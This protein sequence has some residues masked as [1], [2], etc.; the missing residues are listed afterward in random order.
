[1]YQKILSFVLILFFTLIKLAH[2]DETPQILNLVYKAQEMLA[3]EKP[4]LISRNKKVYGR[5]VPLAIYDTE[6]KTILIIRADVSLERDVVINRKIEK[7]VDVSNVRPPD[8]LVY[9]IGGNGINAEFQ[10]AKDG[11]VYPFLGWN[12]IREKGHETMVYSPYTDYLA[13]KE[14]VD[15]GNKYLKTA[16]LNA[17]DELKK[18]FVLSR[19]VRGSLVADVISERIIF[20]LAL[21]EHMDHGE[22]EDKGDVY[23]MNKV[24]TQLALN[25]EKTF[26]YAKSSAGALC[27]MQIMRTTYGGV[28]GKKGK[29]APGVLQLY[30]NAKLPIDPVIGSCGSHSQATKVAYLV[31][32]DKLA[33]MPSDFKGKFVNEPKRYGY[34]LA[35][36]YNGGSGRAINIYKGIREPRIYELVSDIFS[37]FTHRKSEFREYKLLKEETWIFIKKYIEIDTELHK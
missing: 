11:K 7:V 8:Y 27:L 24:L 26:N 35:A 15:F 16:I 37:Y 6:T 25:R 28:K 2:S 20:N 1:M 36:A 13:Q 12:Y 22:Y 18:Q 14:V 4:Y 33:Y 31:L 17:L 32:D 5:D 9:K 3:K 21:I 10:I 23:M 34:V 29:L 30:P 19:A